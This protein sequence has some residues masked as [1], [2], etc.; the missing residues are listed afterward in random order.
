MMRI[1]SR[2][3]GVAAAQIQSRAAWCQQID[4]AP[5]YSSQRTELIAAAARSLGVSTSAIYQHYRSWKSAGQDGLRRAER[6]DKGESRFGALKRR[7][8][9]FATV[10]ERRHWTGAVLISEFRKLEAPGPEDKWPSDAAFRRWLAEPHEGFD[11]TGKEFNRA[12]SRKLTMSARHPNG[13]WQAD[14]R[15]ADLL[16]VERELDKST[17]ELVEKRR[18]RPFLFHFV[19]V[20]SGVEM[21]G[22]Y[23]EAYDTTAVH[24]A[25]LDAIY[26]DAANELPF[27]GIPEWIYWDNGEQHRSCWAARAA[28]QLGIQLHYSIPAEPTSHGFVESTHHIVK[29][30][31]EARMPGFVGGDNQ[32]DNR[33]LARRVE[34]E[35]HHQAE[36]LTLDELNA[37]YRS[38]VAQELHHTE[39][40]GG[41]TRAERWLR[42][43]PAERRRVPELTDLAWRLMDRETRKVHDGRV[44]L[45][46]VEYTAAHLGELNG[47]SVECRY[48][49]EDIHRVW[50]VVPGHGVC[51]CVATPVEAR[52]YGDIAGHVDLKRRNKELAAFRRAVAEA[53]RATQAAAELGLVSGADAERSEATAATVGKVLNGRQKAALGHTLRTMD[54]NRQRRQAVADAPGL[55][56][57][58]YL[59]R[60]AEVAE[61]KPEAPVRRANLTEA[62]DGLA[63]EAPAGLTRQQVLDAI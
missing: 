16:V 13:V 60:P 29:D 2:H 28:E 26:P 7:W 3:E 35:T 19:D 52:F 58:H 18:Y 40:R 15:T 9:A 61:L 36:L 39:Y 45:N 46:T 27:C 8:I 41:A 1:Q 56:K 47:L 32:T 17:D 12:F 38:W 25:L 20:E 50:I 59:P 30:R 14:Q 42:D 48:V 5:A 63:D 43:C 51:H 31:F 57:V 62:L 49:R 34:D 22:G 21:G 23:F 6:S 11:L 24:Y 55:A 54:E 33:P 10:T 4:D 44:R 53:N 37:A